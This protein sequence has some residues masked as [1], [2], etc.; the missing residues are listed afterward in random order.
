VEG[1]FAA[2]LDAGAK[3]RAYLRC[4]GKDKD[5]SRSPSRMT[6]K[7]G[8]SKIQGF[9]ASLRMTISEGNDDL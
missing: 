1:R 9:F 4:N 8:K 3:A 6:N 5:K 7:K 2:G